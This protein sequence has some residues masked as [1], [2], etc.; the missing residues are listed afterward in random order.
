MALESLP[1]HLPVPQDDGA[2][3]HLPGMHLPELNLRMTSGEMLA[4][5]QL[6]GRTVLYIYPMTGH[7]E[8]NLPSDWDLL[9]GARGCTPQ[10]CAFRDHHAEL[11][12]LGADVYG[13]SS[14]GSAYQLEAKQRLRLPFELLSDE[15]L[16]LAQLLNL[17]TLE[18]AELRQLSPDIPSKLFR[19]V[20]LIISASR[21]E[22][23]F[24]PVFPPDQNAVQVAAHLR[25]ASL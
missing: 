15:Q 4:L 24:Y 25:E 8:R 22:Q 9:P 7:P 18:V 20:T 13:I 17:P 12:A 19:R 2:C 1:K 23:V 6:V 16:E 11:K 14:Q 10:S 21:V 5:N 3:D